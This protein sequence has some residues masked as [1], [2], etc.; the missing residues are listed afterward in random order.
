MRKLYRI[1][2]LPEERVELE[3][4]S[5][6]RTAAADK[7][8]KARALLLCDESDDGKGLKDPDVIRE[9][10][11]KYRT[12]QRLRERCCEVGPLDALVRKP[13]QNPSRARKLNGKQ[14]AQLAKLAC[15][16]PPAGCA[17]WSLRLLADHIV[18]LKIVDDIS[19][20][21]VRRELKKMKLNLG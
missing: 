10:G 16:Q 18:E 12:L 3:A 1:K 13:Q 21:T 15:S 7:V 19:H 6:K 5:R 2:L 8:I 11:I 14:Q 4:L 9:T 20:E 17:G